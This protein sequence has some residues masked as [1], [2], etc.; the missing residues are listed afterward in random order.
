MLTLRPTKMLARRLEIEVPPVAPPVT[1]HVA[2][3]CVHEFRAGRFRYLI[4]CN[5]ASIFP[6]VT[7]AR[8]VTDETTLIRHFCRT[9][10]LQLEDSPYA[11]SYQRWI[12]PEVLCAQFAPIPD[13]AVLGTINDL[14]YSAKIMLAAGDLSPVE[15]SQLLARTPLSL[16]GMNSPNRV[17][18]QLGRPSV[19]P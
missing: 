7:F 12:A 4:F 17:F 18:P 13:R 5:L 10:Q 1:N 3:W 8:G 16:L 9:A 14:V 11:F 15:L 6:L 19:D 2:D